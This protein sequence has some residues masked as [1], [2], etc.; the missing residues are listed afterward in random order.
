MI[1]DEKKTCLLISN[2]P[3]F[4]SRSLKIID[5]F[6][7]LLEASYMYMLAIA[8]PNCSIKLAEFF[9]SSPFVHSG[10]K[11]LDFF[12][13]FLKFHEQRRALQLVINQLKLFIMFRDISGDILA[14]WIYLGIYWLTGYIWGYTGS[15]DNYV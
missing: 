12:K 2:F 10:Y 7:V 15:L 6:L 14:H 11:K 3:F 1:K 5:G 8:R 4:I 9:R 13:V